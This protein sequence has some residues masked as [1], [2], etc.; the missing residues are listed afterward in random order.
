MNKKDAIW[1]RSMEL[2]SKYCNC[3]QKPERSLFINGYQFPLC[4]RCTGIALGY[5]AALIT[6]PFYS[7]GYCITVLLFPLAIDGTLQY[8]TAYES[9]NRKRVITGFLYGFAFTSII[10]R[11]IKTIIQKCL[12]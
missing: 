7:F 8:V 2:C 6:I 11:I 1:I 9:T 3:H 5:L 10:F 12:H 4:A